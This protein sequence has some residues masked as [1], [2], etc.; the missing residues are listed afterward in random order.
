MN[1]QYLTYII[2]SLTATLT[3]KHPNEAEVSINTLIICEKN[4]EIVTSVK[5]L[6]MGP[7][8]FRGAGGDENLSI[9]LNWPNL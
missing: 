8:D 9:T 2:A 7:T 4:Q 5:Y 6:K 1:A 3:G